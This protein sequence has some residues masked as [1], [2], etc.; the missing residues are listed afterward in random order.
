KYIKVYKYQVTIPNFKI[1]VSM[2]SSDYYNALSDT[3]NDKYAIKAFSKNITFT[4]VPV[5][6][7]ETFPDN[8]NFSWTITPNA[9]GSSS[10]NPSGSST[11]A[12]VTPTQLSLS[13]SNI[14][15]DSAHPTE[16]TVQCTASHDYAADKQ[17]QQPATAKVFKA[18]EL[19][20]CAIDMSNVTTTQA[21][22]ADNSSLTDNM[23]RKY[24]LTGDL[25]GGFTF[26]VTNAS[27]FPSGT[28]FHWKVKA[29]SLTAYE[30]DGSSELTVSLNSLHLTNSNISTSSASPTTIT[31][32]CEAR[33]TNAVAS[34]AATQRSIKVYK[35]TLP[36]GTATV[37]A[38][39]NVEDPA[40]SAKYRVDD[41]SNEFTF[42]LSPS[43]S[44]FPSS[45]VTRNWYA[46][47][48]NGAFIDLHVFAE[49]C[50]KSVTTMGLTNDTISHDPDHP[51]PIRIKCTVTC[52]TLEKDYI[53]DIYI[54]KNWGS[55]TSPDAI[56]D[57]VFSDG[58]AVSYNSTLNDDQK[59]KAVAIIVNTSPK[60]GVGLV[61]SGAVKFSEFAFNV[62]D[63]TIYSETDG[64]AN[65][66]LIT[67]T[68]DYQTS[69][70]SYEAVHY[71]AAYSATGYTSGWYLPAKDE[72][73]YIFSDSSN[74]TKI[75]DAYT[76]LGLS[77]PWHNAS[78]WIW[79]STPVDDFITN[80]WQKTW[81][82]GVHIGYWE[83]KL[84][85]SDLG[86]VYPF[87]RF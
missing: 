6:N 1:N 9:T 30:I 86:S 76:S 37:T 31:I 53:K 16:I 82:A 18:V 33:K 36:D 34:S 26:K 17:A 22:N 52:D 46:S 58:S 19:P 55:K 74:L 48:N 51:T 7:T 50:I 57:I 29:G 38:S 42:G 35:L 11:S 69:P 80:F 4:A 44:S 70:L 81:E 56:G 41:V 14:S 24:A 64:Q 2:N 5:N 67:G 63:Y 75:E 27:S 77:A 73:D 49:S 43:S 13:D 79:T 21:Y 54:W 15:I 71:C 39:P 85:A 61:R 3:A 87:H 78:D 59:A 20:S 12:S 72:I 10:T 65:T 32:D 25:N 62:D 66:A 8:M 68:S 45:G 28:Y 47:V 60:C 23:N 40:N 83:K 84:P